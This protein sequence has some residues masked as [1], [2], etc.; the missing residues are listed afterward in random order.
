VYT[1][2]IFRRWNRQG[3]VVIGHDALLTVKCIRS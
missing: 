3:D 2:L 1:A